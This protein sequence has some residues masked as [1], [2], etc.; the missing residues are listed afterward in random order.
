MGPLERAVFNHW[1]PT[2]KSH[3]NWW[4]VSSL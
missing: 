3:Y 1:T 2:S 4:S